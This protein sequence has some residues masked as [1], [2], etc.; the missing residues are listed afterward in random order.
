MYINSSKKIYINAFFQV[1]A[2]ADPRASLQALM[3]CIERT[4]IFQRKKYSIHSRVSDTT[5]R[6]YIGIDN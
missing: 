4:K 1:L 6:K 2:A 3:P 5:R